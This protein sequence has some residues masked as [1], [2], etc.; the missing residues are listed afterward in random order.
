MKSQGYTGTDKDIGKK[1]NITYI[2]SR[3]LNT[4]NGWYDNTESERKYWK[5]E[6]QIEFTGITDDIL[7]DDSENGS[8]TQT[9][10][11]DKN[12][13]LLYEAKT[14]YEMRKAKDTGIEAGKLSSLVDEILKSHVDWR[15]LLRKYCIKATS[16][17]S[18]FNNPDKRMFYQDAIYPGQAR[19]E[20]TTIKGVKI[21]FDSSGSI[22]NKDIAYYFGQVL[23][24]MQHFKVDSEVIYWD[25]EVA[26]LGKAQNI[27]ELRKIDVCGRGGTDPSCVFE[28]FDSKKC[29]I[30]PVVTLIFTDGFINFEREQG[31]WKKKYKDTIWIM[32]RDANKQFTPPFGIVTQA[33]YSEK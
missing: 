16:T 15:K 32:T 22:S 6:M 21:C 18:S 2:G 23:E 10:K 27:K 20:S 4:A 5:F 33:K 17:D 14:R 29:H 7:D 26:S 13:R 31:K 9:E 24:L 1:F 30:K 19:D 11:E 25:T 3:Q 8:D 12:K 28:Y